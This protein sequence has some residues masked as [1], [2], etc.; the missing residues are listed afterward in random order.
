MLDPNIVLLAPRVRIVTRAI[1]D[2]WV[3]IQI[4]DT[5]LGINDAIRSRI[6]DPFF[7]TKPIG[8]GTGLGLSTSYQTIKA[9][10]GGHISQREISGETVF[11][12]EIPRRQG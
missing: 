7:T 11:S 4:S 10:H 3:Q 9:Q 8:Q 1:D 5:G 6:F 12:I 2:D